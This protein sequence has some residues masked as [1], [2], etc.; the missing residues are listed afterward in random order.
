MQGRVYGDDEEVRVMKGI[1]VK[2]KDARDE[3][4]I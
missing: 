2:E 4:G 3:R 1:A